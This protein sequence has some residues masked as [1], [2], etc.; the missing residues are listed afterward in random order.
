LN[1]EQL[2][3]YFRY[4]FDGGLEKE[5]SFLWDQLA[6]NSARFGFDDLE[7]EVNNALKNLAEDI[8]RDYDSYQGLVNDFGDYEE[9]MAN[10]TG[11][12]RFYQDIQSAAEVVKKWIG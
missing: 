6:V 3:D 11:E 12:F 1:I 7:D 5:R 8:I 4:L 10:F 9:D 2:H